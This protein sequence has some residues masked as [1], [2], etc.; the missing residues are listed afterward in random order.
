MKTDQ[1]PYA[2]LRYDDR[3]ET[4]SEQQFKQAVADGR[5]CGCGICLACAALEYHLST[6]HG[7]YE[8]QEG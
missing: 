6:V 2:M 1:I 5:A 7:R 3:I 4:F 8:T